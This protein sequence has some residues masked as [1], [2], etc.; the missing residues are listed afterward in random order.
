MTC[1]DSSNTTFTQTCVGAGL[2]FG[3][4]N[5][6]EGYYGWEGALPEENSTYYL[7][8][9]GLDLTVAMLPLTGPLHGCSVWQDGRKIGAYHGTFRG[10][11][12]W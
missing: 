6:M 11:G 2:A 3:L 1:D 8:C 5:Y 10:I 12:V 9:G 4:F 7:M